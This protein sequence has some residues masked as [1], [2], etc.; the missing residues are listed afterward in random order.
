MTDP[1]RTEARYHLSTLVLGEGALKHAGAKGCGMRESE[2]TLL[3]ERFAEMREFLTE[4]RRR[5][6]ARVAAAGKGGSSEA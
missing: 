4:I 1:A 3:I 5:Q 2:Y 6:D